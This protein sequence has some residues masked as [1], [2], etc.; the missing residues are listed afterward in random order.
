MEASSNLSVLERL[1]KSDPYREQLLEDQAAL[2]KAAEQSEDTLALPKAYR[3]L[4]ARD[5]RHQLGLQVQIATY[6]SGARG[7]K[8]RKELVS[9][10]NAVRKAEEDIAQPDDQLDAEQIASETS[11]AV[12][13]LADIDSRLSTV[14]EE[15]PGVQAAKIL[16]GLGFSQ[17]RIDGPY[18]SL[19]GGWRTRCSIASGLFRSSDILLLDEPTNFL[20]VPSI[21]WLKE[22]VNSLKKTIVVVTHDRDFGDAISSTL[23]LIKDAAILSFHGTLS[24]YIR[25]TRKQARYMT[26]MKDAQEKQEQQ[27]K[28]QISHHVQAAKKSGDDKKLKQAASRKKKLDDRMGLTVSAKGGRFKLNRDLA[29]YHLRARADIDV[30]QLDPPVEIAMP[31]PPKLSVT[32][33]LLSF[34]GVGFY[35]RGAKKYLLHK[36][37]L[38]IG[39]QDRVG[40]VGLNGAGKSTLVKLMLGPELDPAQGLTPA[41]GSVQRASRL[42]IG[43]FNQSSVED[44]ERLSSQDHCMTALKHL[45]SQGLANMAES[46]IRSVLSGLG[47]SGRVVSNVP[48]MALSGGQKVRVAL[49]AILLQPPHLLV[50]DE[51]TCHLDADSVSGLAK[52][53]RRYEGAVVVVSHDRYFTRRVVEEK[54]DGGEGE[55][56]SESED[57]EEEDTTI[58]R[59]I[60]L[61]ENRTVKHL[62]GGVAEYEERCARKKMK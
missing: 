50:L 2:N 22:Y 38:Q 49:A 35:Y 14:T 21:L 52:A 3:K 6:R 32:G 5:L 30:P 41:K 43:S 59:S 42:R 13:M 62:V 19:S 60:L 53:L 29:G 1:V 27:I 23:L 4:R 12:E 9:L 24:S 25:E 20:D 26:K 56:S 39:P 7:F 37:N 46:E 17:T 47:L 54:V 58:R 40:L 31:Q 28:Q 57:E 44:I 8:A 11:L 48:L 51:V 15:A 36:V 45:M 10:E 16:R 55:S 33:N 34:D 18:A 61:V